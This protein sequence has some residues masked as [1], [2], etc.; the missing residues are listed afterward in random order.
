MAATLEFLLVV[1]KDNWKVELTAER[2][3]DSMAVRKVVWM[4]VPKVDKTVLK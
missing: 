2:M 4:A 1:E 3:G